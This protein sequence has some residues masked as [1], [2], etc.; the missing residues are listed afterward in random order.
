MHDPVDIRRRIDRVVALVDDV[1]AGFNEGIV[2][3]KYGRAT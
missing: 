3:A 1:E 2:W